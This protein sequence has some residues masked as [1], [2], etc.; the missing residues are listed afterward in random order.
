MAQYIYVDTDQDLLPWIEH[1]LQKKLIAIDTEFER[2]HTYFP[3][4]SLIQ[5]HD[6]THAFLVD[7]LSPAISCAGHDG[8]SE[9]ISNPDVIKV[10]HSAEE[11]IAVLYHKLGTAPENI[12]DSQIAAEI[13]GLAMSLSYSALV[14]QLQHVHLTKSQTRTNWLQR[15]LTQ[16]QMNYAAEDVIYLLPIYEQLRHKI[17]QQGRSSWI[18]E[19]NACKR[20]KAIARYQEDGSSYFYR[21]KHRNALDPQQQQ[22]L[23]QLC[24]WRE[25]TA[26]IRDIPRQHVLKDMVLQAIAK[27]ETI[28]PNLPYFPGMQYEQK[29]LVGYRESLQDCL[30]LAQNPAKQRHISLD[31]ALNRK[32]AMVLKKLIRYRNKQAEILN[33][34]SNMLASKHLLTRLVKAHYGRNAWHV[35]Q[36]ITG[37]R[38]AVILPGFMQQLEHIEPVQVST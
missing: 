33:I 17:A 36:V 24:L 11:D 19:E 29:K 37:W 34:N 8:L 32:Q 18:S 27:Q 7:L 5:V 23:M 14:D 9:L 38:A 22:I 12:F 20:K 13:A 2:T 30:H 6:G 3:V 1:W 28:D 25:Q 4:L 31:Q 26:R 15:P 10:I 16:D 21:I 35:H